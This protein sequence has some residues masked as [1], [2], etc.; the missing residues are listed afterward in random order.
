ML[1]FAWETINSS[2]LLVSPLF[3]PTQ[4]FIETERFSVA[5]I[6]ASVPAMEAG[7]T[8]CP[9]GRERPAQVHLPGQQRNLARIQLVRPTLFLTS[10]S[11]RE[12]GRQKSRQAKE[13]TLKGRQRPGLSLPMKRW[14][15]VWMFMTV[16]SNCFCETPCYIFIYRKASGMVLLLACCT[17][18]RWQ[19]G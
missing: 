4:M 10:S 19:G 8:S 6:E 2:W 13:I 12:T 9:R 17:M 14:V 16:H 15:R 7:S 18:N 5:T 1:M 3:L 11:T